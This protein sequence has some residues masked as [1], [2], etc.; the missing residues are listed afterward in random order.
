MSND[1]RK[2]WEG[3]AERAQAE[4]EARL[5]RKSGINLGADPAAEA[6]VAPGKA[7]GMRRTAQGKEVAK[8]FDKK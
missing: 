7:E 8:K 5:Q 4:A 1:I 3:A 6:R 2:M